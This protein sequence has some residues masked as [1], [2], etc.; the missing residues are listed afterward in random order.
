MFMTNLDGSSWDKLEWR[1]RLETFGEND[2]PII[3]AGP[4]GKV[5]S[6]W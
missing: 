5:D 6:V 4:G 3:S 2:E 1:R